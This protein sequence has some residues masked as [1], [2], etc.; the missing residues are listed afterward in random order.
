MRSLLMVEANIP[1]D[2]LIAALSYDGTP[3][4]AAFVRAAVL[5]RLRQDK[6]AAE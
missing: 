3:T 1:G 4:T 2:K 5:K 6:Q